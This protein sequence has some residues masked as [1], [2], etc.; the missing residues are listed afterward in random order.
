MTMIERVAR[1]I[2]NMSEADWNSAQPAW[3]DAMIMSAVR[4][5]H[6]MREPTEKMIR[7]GFSRD[8]LPAQTWRQMID[9]ALNE[10]E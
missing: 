10:K 1:A 3:K 8:D 7:H 9:A 4:A 6:A 5:L 2:G